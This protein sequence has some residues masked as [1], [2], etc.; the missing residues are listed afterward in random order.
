MTRKDGDLVITRIVTRNATARYMI[1]D[2]H[3]RPV[4]DRSSAVPAAVAQGQEIRR[5]FGPE[6]GIP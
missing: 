5:I 1:G 2:H 3:G 6:C 4:G